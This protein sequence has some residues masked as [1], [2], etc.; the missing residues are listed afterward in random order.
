[1]NRNHQGYTLLELIVSVGIFSM[2]MLIVTGAYLAL[3]SL[4]RKARAVNDLSSN[5]SFA[6][7]GMTRSIRTGKNFAC[8]GGGDGTC[9]QMSFRDPDNNTV[10]YLLKTS[11]SIG[12]CTS[13]VC[14]DTSAVALTDPRIRI[15]ALTFYIRGSSISDEVQ[16][17]VIITIRGNILTEVGKQTNFAVQAAATQRLIDI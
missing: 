15:D 4:D 13:G 7:D 5:F 14:S 6:L 1:M 3:I 2:V 10:T 9:S 11:G 16:P 8:V 12:Q 17:Q